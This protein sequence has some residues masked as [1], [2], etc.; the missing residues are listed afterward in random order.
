MSP[1][2]YKIHHRQLAISSLDATVRRYRRNAI[3]LRK[4]LSY[5]KDRAD[6]AMLLGYLR[7]LAPIPW[8]QLH[9]RIGILYSALMHFA[10]GFN[11]DEWFEL[12]NMNNPQILKRIEHRLTQT[13]DSRTWWKDIISVYN[14]I[15][16]AWKW[17]EEKFDL[18]RALNDPE[19][20]SQINTVKILD[21]SE[22][23]HNTSKELQEFKAQIEK[24]IELQNQENLRL[25]QKVKELTLKLEAI[26][27]Q[28]DDNCKTIYSSP[29]SSNNSR[30]NYISRDNAHPARQ[31]T[32]ASLT[33]SL[34]PQINAPLTPQAN[35]QFVLGSQVK[36]S[37]ESTHSKG[38]FVKPEAK[39][40][41]KST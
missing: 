39:P 38:N 9:D 32:P 16:N 8:I 3:L 27:K 15:P 22:I 41:S 29:P 6:M 33:T 21:V 7:Q 18:I 23:A 31:P 30:R 13:E 10:P 24:K 40:L 37:A 12:L 1:E 28:L 35:F 2:V 25:V 14:A 17:E 5:G 26:H 19:W 36:T 11:N 4:C 20:S 34:M